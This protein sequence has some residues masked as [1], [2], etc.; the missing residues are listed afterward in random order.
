MASDQTGSAGL[1]SQA[2]SGTGGL[3]DSQGRTY[4]S[5]TGG[6]LQQTGGQMDEFI[7]TQPLAAVLIALGI[8]YILGRIGL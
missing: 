1:G 4:S 8:G 3:L 2:Q 7:R 6:Q 5:S